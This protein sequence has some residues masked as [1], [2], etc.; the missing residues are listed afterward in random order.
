MVADDQVSG[1]DADRDDDI[2]RN[3]SCMFLHASKP[4]GFGSVVAIN[5]AAIS[6]Y[7]S[8]LF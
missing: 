4:S 6:L 3:G 5:R 1:A 2:S 7:F 8:G